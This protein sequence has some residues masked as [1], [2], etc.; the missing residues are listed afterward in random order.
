MQKKQGQYL[1]GDSMLPDSADPL[2]VVST[3]IRVVA[4]IVIVTPC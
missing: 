4:G 2:G 1:G 3:L